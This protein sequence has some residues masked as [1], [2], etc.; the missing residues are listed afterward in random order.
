MCKS[1][2]ATEILHDR[3]S[4]SSAGRGK[5][6]RHVYTM[7]Y[8]NHILAAAIAGFA[9]AQ[10]EPDEPWMGQTDLLSG[11]RCCIRRAREAH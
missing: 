9:D 1:L 8:P 4:G 11:S 2:V 6:L 10:G 3:Q 7:L 5:E